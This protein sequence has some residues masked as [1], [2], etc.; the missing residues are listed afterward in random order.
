MLE[1]TPEQ[2][3]QARER[4]LAARNQS[5]RSDA[6]ITWAIALPLW[7]MPEVESWTADMFS[8]IGRKVTR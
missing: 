2:M 4:R 3:S 1:G 8:S 5:R 7:Q 6:A